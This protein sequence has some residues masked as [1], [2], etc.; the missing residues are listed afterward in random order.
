M[1]HKQAMTLSRLAILLA[2]LIAGCAGTL[3]GV[4]GGSA[5]ACKAP[6]G[7]TCASV[8]GVY[9]NAVANN[10]PGQQQ[11]PRPEKSPST[12][13]EAKGSSADSS[14]A[15]RTPG[16]GSAIRSDPRI[17]RIWLAP[18]EDSDGD[19][20]D[21]AYVYVTVDAGKWLI[22]HNRAPIRREFAPLKLREQ[23]GATKTPTSPAA[24]SE[25]T[26]PKPSES[27][28]TPGDSNVQ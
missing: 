5:F 7:T 19:L 23:P 1:T 28:I 13:A 25:T 21:Q 2:P 14:V 24:S 17:L 16:S 18:W 12:N 11:Q 3:S 10:L 27:S 8:A 20:H 6:P 4:G 9:A 15:A 26:S 22:E